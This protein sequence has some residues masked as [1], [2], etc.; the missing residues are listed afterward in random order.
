LFDNAWPSNYEEIKT[1]YPVWYREV[2]EMDALWRIWGKHLDD[3][4]EAIILSV[5]NNFIDHADAQTIGRLETF[6]GIVYDSPRTL[7]ERRN[8]IKGFIIGRGKIGRQE[9]INLI[10]IFT[11][12]TIDVSFAGGVIYI[13]VTRDF[14]DAF[15]L[16]DIHLVLD[17]RIPA[18]LALDLTDTRLPIFVRNKNRFI[19][20]DLKMAFVIQNPTVRITGELLDGSKLLDG[21]WLLESGKTA[22]LNFVDFAMR[23]RIQNYG[24]SERGL[25]LNGLHPLDGSFLLNGERQVIMGGPSLQ[26]LTISG[27]RFVNQFSLSAGA[28]Y[29]FVVRNENDFMLEGFAFNNSVAN[30]FDGMNAQR[31]GITGFGI[32]NEASSISGTLTKSGEWSLDGTFNLDGSQS[33]EIFTIKEEL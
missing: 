17:N 1:W 16:Y 18:H 25:I 5:D 10:S 24:A 14:G 33:L 9:I 31:L 26:A 15:N 29:G 4:Q 23:A 21:S 8:V 3:I 32:Q 13:Y 7:Y 28:E 30:N 22:G 20:R 19:F 27:F 2:L 12:G 11:S 6:F